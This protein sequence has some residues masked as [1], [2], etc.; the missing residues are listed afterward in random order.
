[1]CLCLW[2]LCVD[3]YARGLDNSV[4]LHR[5]DIRYTLRSII[6]PHF[7]HEPVALLTPDNQVLIYHIGAGDNAT[8]PGS[9]YATNCSSHCTGADHKWEGGSTFY[10][11][12]AIMSS[13][14]FDGPFVTNI[15]GSG[16]ALAGCPQCGD[17]NPAPVLTGPDGSITMMWRTTLLEPTPSACP[18]KSCMAL[19]RAP[20]WQG[21]YA[22]STSNIFSGQ[23]AANDTHI[24]DAH[25][26]R[27]PP[28]AANPGS[29]HAIFHSDVEKT[30]GGAAGG[31][32]WSADGIAWTFS[33][34]N[35]YGRTVELRNGSTLTLRQRERP[36]LGFDNAGNPV[37][38]TNG[39]GLVGDCDHVF[40][41]AQLI[42][43]A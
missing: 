41:F 33:P 16:S 24:E 2:S 4:S 17:T 3:D 25:L 34:L 37:V 10:G 9:N 31:H 29:Y 8:G 38:L 1:M 18:A 5:R 35:A 19:A 12:T 20:R 36:H 7:A 42:K 11:P 21:P 27:A 13:S 6:K 26:W 30:C 23:P 43:A 14:S 28:T 40:T 32:A 22:W 39:V 15:I